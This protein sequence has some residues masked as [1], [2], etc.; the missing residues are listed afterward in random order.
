M[1]QP[2]PTFAKIPILDTGKFEQWMFRIQQYLQNKHY[3]LLEVI[4][5]GDSYE[6]PQEESGTGSKSESSAKKKRR[7]VVISTEDMQKRRNDRYRNDL[8]TL[9]LDDV[10]NHLKVYEPEVQKKSESNSQN[11]AF[12][13]SANT[14]SG[15]GEVNTASIPTASTQV[16]PAS[17][18]VAAASINQD[19]VC[20]YIASQSN[21][22]QIKYEDINQIDED[23]IKE[24]DIKRIGSQGSVAIDGVGWDWSYMANEEENHALVADDKAQTEFALMAKSSFKNEVEARLVEFKTQ[25]IKFC[26]KIRGLEFNVKNKNTKI[27][28]FMN[29]LEQ[30][31]KEKE[32]LDRKL[33]GFESASKDLKTLLG[34]QR[35]DKNKEGLRYSAV[36]PLLLKPSPS[37]KSNS[38]DL[39]N[40]NSSVSGHEESSKSIMSKPM[41]K[42]V[43]AADSPTV[44]KT[45]KVETVRK[46]SVKYAEMYRNTSKSPKGNSQNNIDDKG[47]WYSGSSRHMTGNI[48]YLSDY[49]P[50]DGGYVSFGQGGGKITGKVVSDDFYR[51]T[52]T[53]FLKT[54]DETS[55]ILRNF[56]T[57][58][59]NLKDL[60]VKIIRCDK[61]G[62]FK[63]KEI[64]E[65]CTMKGI[66][67]EFNNARSPQQNGVAKRKNRTLIEAART[68]VFN[69]RTKKVEEI[70]H[71]DCLEN[72]LIKKGAGPNWLFDIDTL[73][74]STN[75]VPVVVAE[76]SSTNFSGIKDA[77]SQDVKKDVASLRYIA[78]P[79]WFHEAH[80]ESSTSNAQDACNADAPESSGNYNLTAT[81]INSSAD[82]IKSLTVES[83]IPTVSLPVL[84]AF[85]NDSPETSSATR[86]ISKRVISQ[87]E[88]PSLDNISTL[89]NRFEDILRVT[90]NTG[91]TNGVEAD[92]GNM[93]YNISASPTPTLRIHKDHPKNQI[94]SLVDTPVHTRHKSKEMEEQSLIATIHQKTNLDLLQLCLFSFFLSQEEPKK[95]SDALK[96]PSWGVR[97]IGTK[98]VL[99]NKKDERGIMIRNKAR[100]VAQGYTQEEEIHYEEIFVPVA[101]IEAIRLFLA[102]ASFMGFTDPEFPDRVYKVDKAIYRLHQAPR[103]WYG[104][105]SKYLLANDFQRDVRS[106][107]TPMEKENPWGKDGPGKDVDL[108]LYR[109]MIGSLMYLTAFRP[110]I[111]FAYPKESP[112]DL[113]TYSDSD[114]GGASQDRKS[115]TRG[116]QFLGRRLISWQCKK[117]TIMA[118]STT[119]AEYVVAASG[120]G[121]VLAA[122]KNNV[123]KSRK[124]Y[125]SLWEVII[126]GDSPAPTV[127]I[128]GAVRPVTFFLPSKWKT[129]TLIWRNK[130]DLEEH[131][132]DD[133]FNSLRIYEAKVKHS[134]TL[135]NPIQNLAFV[136]SSNTDSTTDLV[137]AATSVSTICAQLPVSSHPNIDSL[138]NAVIFSFFASQSTSPQNASVKTSTSNALVSQYDGIGSYDWSYQAE[139]EHANFALMAITSS[140][141]SSDNE[142]QSCSKACS[143][144][145][146][147]LHSQYDKLTVEFCESQIKVLSYQ[148]GLESV[149]ARLV[150]YKQNESILQ[151]NIN[152]LKNEV[153]ARDNVLVTLKQKLNQAEKER[154]DLKLKFNKFQTSSKILTELLASP[155]NDKHGLGYFSESDSKSLSPSS[156]SDRL[157][158]SG[159]YNAV[160]PPIIRNFMPPKRNLFFHTAPI[161]VEADHLAFT[162]QLSPTKPAKDIFY[163]T[164]PMTPII[165]DWVSY[166]EDK[167]EPNDLRSVSSLVHTFEHVKPSGHPV[168]PV[169][170][171]ILAATPKPTS[172]KTNCSG[173]RKNRK[174]CFVCRSVDHLIKDCNFYAKLKTQPTPRNYAHRGY[175]KQHASSTKKYLQKHIVP[176]AVLTKS[177][178][179]SVTTV[180]PVSVIVPKIMVTRPRH[181]HSLNTRSNSTIRRHKTRS[182]SLK[183]SNSSSK[184]TAAKAQVVS[185]AKGKKEK[186][187]NPQYAL[188]DKG[189]ID[190]GCSRH[191]TGNMSYLFDFQEL[192]GGYVAFG[193]NP[194]GGK[195]SGKGKIKTDSLLPIPFWAE[196]V[197][198]VCY[199]QNRVLVTKPH[200]KT[201]YELLHGRTP[202][203][204][205]MRPFG[206]LVI[207]LN[208]LDPLGKFEGKVD[209]GFLV[210][211]SINSKAFRVYNNKTRI[212]QETLH[213]NFL[214]N[215]PNIAGEEAE[216]QYMLFPMW[217]TGSSNLQNKEGD[218]AFDVKKHDA[219]KPESA[220]NLYPSS[221]ALLGEQ[222]DMTKKKDKGKI[223]TAGQNYSNSTNLISAI[224]PSHSNTSPTHEKSSFRDISQPSEM[225]EREDIAYSDHE[226][227]GAEADF[228]NLETSITIKMDSYRSS[229][230]TSIL[231]Y[232]H[233][234]FYKR[235]PRGANGTK[236]VYKNKKDERSIVV[237]NK[238]RLVAQGHTQE[239]GI[240]YEEVFAPVAR[241]EAI[242][243]FLAYASFMGF[244]VYQMDVKSAFLYETI[245][246]EVNV[247][248]PPGF[249]DPNHPDKVKQ[250]KDGIFISQ[251]KYVAEILKKFGLTEGKS[252]STPIDTEKPLLKDPNGYF[253]CV[254]V[255]E[256]DVKCFIS[257]GYLTTNGYQF[258]MSNPHKNWLV[259]IKTVSG[260]DNL[261][262]LMADN[263]PKIVW[264][265]THHVTLNKELASPKA[266]GSWANSNCYIEYALTVN[267]TIYVSCIKQFWNTVAVKQSNDV[268]RLQALVNKKKVVVTEAAIRDALHLDDAE[269]V[270]GLPNE[271]IFTKLARMGYEKS[272]TMLTF[273]KAFFS[274]QWNLV[275]NI[276]SSS[277]FYIYPRFIHLIIQNQL[278]DLSTHTT[279]YISPALTQKIFANMRRVGKGCSA[280]ETSLFKGM[281]VA[282]EPEEQE[283][284]K[285]KIRVKKLERANKVK[286]LKLKRLR[287]VG[288]SQR[289]KSSDDTIMEDVSNQERII[290]ELD[291]DEGVVLMR[292]KEEKETKEVKDITGDA[293]VKE[294][295]AD[296]YQID[297]DHATKVLS[298]K[299]DEPE[300]QEAVE[301]VTTAKLI[302]EVVAAVSEM[303]S[304]AVVVPTVTVDVV[305]AA[306]VTPAPVKVAQQVELDEAYARKLHEE[307]N[308][309]ID[310]EVA[311][312]HVKQKAKENPYVQRYQVMKKRPQTE[313]HARRN[314]M[315]YLKNTVGFR[316]DYF[317]GISYDDIRPIFEPKFNSNIEFLLKSKEQIEEE[318]NRA[319]ASI[320]ETPAQKAAKR[321]RMNEEAKDVE[322][323]KQHL[324]IVPDEDDD[325]YTEATLLARKVPVVDYQIIHL[326]NKPHFTIIRA[327][328]THQLYVNFITL[329]KNFDREYLESLWSIVKE[330]FSTSKPNNFSDDFFLTT[331]RAMFGRPDGQDQVWMSQ[332]SVH[333]DYACRKKIPT[334]E[335]YIGSDAEYSTSKSGRAKSDRKQRTHEFIHVYLAF[336]SVYVWIGLAFYDYHNM[337]SIM[338]KSDH[339]VDFHQIVDFVEASHIRVKAH[340]LQL[341]PITHP[342]LRHNNHHIMI[343]H[344]HIQLPQLKQFLQQH[345]QK[346]PFLCNTL[347]ELHELL[348]PKL[349][350]LLQMSLHFN[351]VKE[352]F[353]PVWKQTEDF[354]L[355]ALKEEGERVKRKGMKLE[356]GSAKNMKTSEDVSKEDLKEMMQLVP[357]EEVYVEA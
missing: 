131:S 67:R 15:K 314:M 274:S 33:T 254:G 327:D 284:T 208:T 60:K 253:K 316:L 280:V 199:V 100:L 26:E 138:S 81:S 55:G 105:L 8:D 90:T 32:G 207:I 71:V 247:C 203:I 180:R 308:Q 232:L 287:K 249:E 141:S 288:T 161:V 298:M 235:N 142:V 44:I 351:S 324:E 234:F 230:M 173:K 241:I 164:R 121:Q 146:D 242:R 275:R 238:A 239:E 37:T 311:M 165:K 296:I 183:T 209:E 345:T 328:G 76:T 265:S 127:V 302:T 353:I 63:N 260:K 95:I 295:Q 101:R 119:E 50:Y 201:P 97:P 110:D 293:Q 79:N 229:M 342:L 159:G 182:Q 278:G 1:K 78:L 357:V 237:R 36:P 286:A 137:S 43:K 114:Y 263:L 336:A 61:K 267:P 356:Q 126:N 139:E 340:E 117:Q 315:V 245:K 322:E 272:S 10:Y 266:N 333:A 270:E 19:N 152:M 188:K 255:F 73:T 65:L 51:F 346:S 277:K 303:V 11:I 134:S 149:E 212:V 283:I 216:Q 64:N 332:R 224:G 107:N 125:Y 195:I 162:V 262:P 5:F 115:T 202:S 2:N 194:K 291:K 338:E 40:S 329:L 191:M 313:A 334:I 56:I 25:E 136:S 318:E 41:I 145:Y 210:R 355:M 68:M 128:D 148:A 226:N 236:W 197:N 123:A 178:P 47:Y 9:S 310:W 319:I 344:H 330:R 75:Y 7:T 221:S 289:I 170:A 307:L 163:T 89:S 91:D 189:V 155:T 122:E 111:M 264:Y 169:E 21:G 257:T 300:I 3:A 279:K 213:V 20:A 13:S 108:H 12:I 175:N 104:T 285:L 151:E 16:S 321:R 218:A 14:S 48:S 54:K 304:A 228:N 132:L 299:K 325:V 49:E 74:N 181:A 246:E 187:G 339:N 176:V 309:D 282:R 109:F 225:L 93:E 305:P 86:L 233:A 18:N 120:C 297:M 34:S 59:E 112:F 153:E 118:T 220:V 103:A 223:S 350:P 23:D 240:D 166:S 17:A 200:N 171:H 160:P 341:S 256:N 222:D 66:K 46:P 215:K 292:E 354:V 168:Q 58:L 312:D 190:S 156:L 269:G 35:S 174:T 192:N 268:T 133:L 301:V 102:Y 154:D 52:W 198:T 45:N 271:E 337:I 290:D 348:S 22:S 69:K 258:T 27:E 129:H 77:A 326:N 167:S 184:V 243:L 147:Q 186:W 347:E 251:E 331:L 84:T 30:I 306:T 24:M 143:K 294:R 219:E 85:L 140:S 261:N 98:W 273:Y 185:A 80:L 158:P 211:Y 113:V 252:A 214:E 83:A 96:D 317:K 217:S 250:K 179:V 116:F 352:K 193:G 42:F 144:A 227:V 53:F 135:G 130:V 244:V 94:I 206:S 281:L 39:Q 259:Q 106:A 31:K 88:T 92:L 57:E 205:F 38:S 204:G 4:E 87:D 62:E 349:F 124:D 28:D 323:L 150:V 231:A 343:F 99:K 6:A 335:V 248:Q 196:V 172:L 82:Q 157:Q 320:N 72:K 29:E 70:L 177:K 276:D